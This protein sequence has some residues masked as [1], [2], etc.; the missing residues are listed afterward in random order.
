MVFDSQGKRLGQATGWR[1]FGQFEPAFAAARD[2]IR[3]ANVV[4][5]TASGEKSGKSST[6]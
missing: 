3:A 2:E 6:D 5:S 1:V 4:G